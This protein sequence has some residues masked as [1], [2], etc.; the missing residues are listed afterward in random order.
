M[1]R[2]R[3]ALTLVLL[4]LLLIALGPRSRT[5]QDAPAPE[6]EVARPGTPPGVD[7]IP[8]LG[9]RRR[10]M[11]SIGPGRRLYPMSPSPRAPDRWARRGHRD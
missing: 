5:L 11:V 1:R 10:T 7:R 9:D 8:T 2:Y 6:A 4:L 3:H